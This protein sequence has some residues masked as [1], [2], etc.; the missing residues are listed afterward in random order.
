MN[1]P[2]LFLGNSGARIQARQVQLRF[3]K[4]LRSAGI[5]RRYTVHSLRH[6]FATRLYEQTGD[7]RLVQRALG[8]RSISTTEIYTLVADT[9]LKR[10]IESLGL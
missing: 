9:R 10:A 2:A 4:W 3:E 6:T 1:S 5:A 8:H 7:I